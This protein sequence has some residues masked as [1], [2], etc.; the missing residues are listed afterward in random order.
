[1]LG[2]KRQT[3]LLIYAY[4][5]YHIGHNHHEEFVTMKGA[6]YLATTQQLIPELF[7]EIVQ[8][9]KNNLQTKT[10][11]HIGLYQK[12]LVW[13]LSTSP[14]SRH[15]SRDHEEDVEQL[16]QKILLGTEERKLTPK[17]QCI[18][19][20]PGRVTQRNSGTRSTPR[21]RRTPRLEIASANMT[22]RFRFTLWR[23]VTK[24]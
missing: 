4:P 10:T 17:L 21:W 14:F 11:V 19:S 5:D 16:D 1:M 8:V 2:E 23:P 9:S 24:Y 20:M 7:Q 18:R 3:P 15:L 12:T 22:K 13:N 6:S